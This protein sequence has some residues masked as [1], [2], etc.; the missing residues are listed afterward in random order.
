MSATE[1]SDNLAE[2]E[3]QLDAAVE[4]AEKS[5]MLGTE[6]QQEDQTDEKQE[7]TQVSQGMGVHQEDAGSQE[8]SEVDGEGETGEDAGEDD[9]TQDEADELTARA[10]RAG[11][12]MRD[13]KAVRSKR[14]L[15]KIVEVL[16]DNIARAE[17]TEEDSDDEQD[18]DEE[19]DP[20]ADLPELDPEVHDE[21]VI[22]AVES[23][24]AAVKKQQE[25]LG[26]YKVQSTAAEKR[27]EEVRQ[28][29]AAEWFDNAV[30]AMGKEFHALL[31]KGRY[32]D[33]PDHSPQLANRE[34]LASQIAV[35]FSGYHATGA[36]APPRDEVFQQAARLVF[37]DEYAEIE[38]QKLAGDLE[39]RSGS[40]ISRPSG[41][42]GKATM[43]PEDEAA[44]MLS[45]R[46]GI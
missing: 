8:D 34:R 22:K 7:E 21:K 28:Q 29:E 37:A 4:D 33:L 20:L 17:Y 16:E 3:S 12:S 25:E 35:L 6:D 43:S 45:E 39:K 26:K 32:N 41:R 38:K 44:A 19:D 31:G 36:K 2:F 1:K 14:S 13:I 10:I 23:L 46:F 40:H 42:K 11:M 9:K 24:K 18:Q 27:A 5:V 15:T 30:D